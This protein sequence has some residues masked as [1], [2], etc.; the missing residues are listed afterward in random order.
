[1]PIQNVLIAN[2]GE[3]A[4]RII[5]ACRERGIRAVAVYSE[6]DADAP[7]VRY[8]DSAYPIGTSPPHQSYLNIDTLIRVAHAA[9]CDSVHPG[10]GFLAE[11]A[12]F[13][14][15]VIDAGLTWIGPSPNAIERMGDKVEARLLM[16]SAN[17][18]VV[19]GFE[20]KG[21]SLADFQSAADDIGYPI[22]VKAAGGGGGKGIRIVPSPAELPDAISAAQNEAQHAF[23]DQRIFL[24]R[25]IERGRHI[26]VQILAD[27][28]GNTVH[29][30]ERECSTQRRHQKI[31]EEAPSPLVDEALRAEIGAAA[32][33]A[34]QAVDYVNAGTIEFIATDEGEFFFLEMNTRIQVE[35]PVT[36]MITGV[37]L[38]QMQLAI[39]DGEALPFTQDDLQHNGHAIECR[40]Y[41]EDPRN[42]FL[43]A[44]GK[45]QQFLPPHA[46]G[47][48]V[49]AGIESGSDITIHYDPMIAKLIVHAPDR[50][51]AIGRMQR[52]L[53]ETV[54]L[55]TTTN[56]DF[57]QA[58][59]AHTMFQDAQ[60]YTR[61]VDEH[62]N[63]LMPPMPTLPDLALIATALHDW[64]GDAPT[65]QSSSITSEGDP[66]S[67]W[68]KQ[69]NFRMGE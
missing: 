13:A 10:Y 55:G 65:S 61:F 28:H 33:R 37:D 64:Q 39:A 50:A 2:R 59:L 34:A 69:D 21:A 42:Q 3:I 56:I 53:R 20:G 46:P 26:E 6:A 48:R 8:A 45:V 54:I 49:D 19:P 32:V 9:G 27:A 57:L 15:A 41:A 60:V 17:V 35:H 1:M 44:I 30:F 68:R 12:D 4:L 25:Y 40:L 22:M 38:V 63:D 24:E 5:H 62:L 58:L 51:T 52:A 47:V 66:Y 31:I 29:L 36:E 67:P 43:P 14:R 16:Q 23:G 11:S 18:P 7:H